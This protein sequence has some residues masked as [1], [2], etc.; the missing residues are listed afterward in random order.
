MG[1]QPTVAPQSASVTPVQAPATEETSTEASEE[2]VSAAL[3]AEASPEGATP[4]P[5]DAD[6]AAAEEQAAVS[7]APF[8]SRER[9]W[10]FCARLWPSVGAAR[11]FP[12]T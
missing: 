8:C 3:P 11:F 2:A 7:P 9:S 12:A 10:T 1:G 4:G 6:D 5:S